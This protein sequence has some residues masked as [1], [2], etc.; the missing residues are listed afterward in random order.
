MLICNIDT[1]RSGEGRESTGLR[2]LG[3][4]SPSL[5][6]PSKTPVI[7]YSN[8]SKVFPPIKVPF[9]TSEDSTQSRATP[10]S[11]HPQQF[12]SAELSGPTEFLDRPKIAAGPLRR[13]QPFSFARAG[14]S[15]INSSG[16]FKESSQVGER[17]ALS[18]HPESPSK[19]NTKS[20]SQAGTAIL[21]TISDPLSFK[22]SSVFVSTYCPIR[23]S[24]FNRTGLFVPENQHQQSAPRIKLKDA[25]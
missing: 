25:Q 13:F 24:R 17:V 6:V 23:P 21:C 15:K 10:S 2:A 1:L 14:Q 7:E 5:A 18:S 12:H 20:K 9:S 19:S 11:A 8:T 3:N 22:S 16:L 4:N